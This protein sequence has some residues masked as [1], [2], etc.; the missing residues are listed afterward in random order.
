MVNNN[1][2]IATPHV[3]PEITAKFDHKG[4]NF[5]LPVK[6]ILT[7]IS[8]YSHVYAILRDSLMI[9]EMEGFATSRLFIVV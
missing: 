5:F 9:I 6:N 1:R 7:K 8:R 4:N 3:V 2:N